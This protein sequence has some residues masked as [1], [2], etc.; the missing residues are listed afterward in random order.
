ML[1]FS[2]PLGGVRD[3]PRA[4]PCS[5][6][7]PIATWADVLAVIEAHSVGSDASALAADA[8]DTLRRPNNDRL[9]TS[10][11]V[12]A[13]GKSLFTNSVESALVNRVVVRSIDDADGDIVVCVDD[14][15]ICWYSKVI[16]SRASM[17]SKVGDLDRRDL[18]SRSS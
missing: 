18:L 10:L 1:K 13:T 12:D 7:E 15:A 3:V 2:A 16:R 11:G 4:A 8:D 14:R 9:K 6:T 5:S 17:E